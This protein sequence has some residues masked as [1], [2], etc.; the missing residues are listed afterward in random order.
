MTRGV[1]VLWGILGCS[2][3]GAYRGLE[4]LEIRGLVTRRTDS[5]RRLSRELGA[6]ATYGYVQKP[7]QG[8]R[9]K[10]ASVNTYPEGHADSD[11]Y[12]HRSTLGWSLCVQGKIR[13]KDRG[14]GTA[15]RADAVGSC[16]R[17]PLGQRLI[18]VYNV[19]ER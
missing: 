10:A 4:E 9:T 12:P 7:L 14:G 13:C 6:L 19:E 2:D 17:S 1:V 18:S 8:A 15:A 5:S 11:R 3:A 16:S